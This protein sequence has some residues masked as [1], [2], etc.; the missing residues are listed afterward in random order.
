M[1]TMHL[2]MLL[3]SPSTLASS[4]SNICSSTVCVP[5]TYNRMDMP[6]TEAGPLQIQ[7]EMIL[8]EVYEVNAKDLTIHINLFM[9][10]IWIDNRLNFTTVSNDKVD[11]GPE[12]I[13]SIWTPDFYIYHM[14]EMG[15]YNGI[16]ASK[17][18]T[19]ERVDSSIRLIYSMEANVKFMCPMSFHLFPFDSNTCQFRLTSYTFTSEKMVFKALTDIRPDVRLVKEKVR[20][21]DITVEYLDGHQTTQESTLHRVQ[22]ITKINYCFLSKSKYLIDHKRSKRFL[23]LNF[24][25]IIIFFFK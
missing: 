3:L 12:F 9:N 10:F 5:D 4:P 8:M 16:T 20:D 11:M 18:L 21:Y 23:F 13:G 17:G 7:T 19:V 2:L 6:K 1:K 22:K 15:G 25:I 24:S 14:K